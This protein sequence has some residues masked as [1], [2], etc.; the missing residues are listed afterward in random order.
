MIQRVPCRVS[1]RQTPEFVDFCGRA[2]GRHNAT[3]G[4]YGRDRAGN[5]VA[6]MA[7]PPDTVVEP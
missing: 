1:H 2:R 3:L 5:L 4:A 7:W 6:V